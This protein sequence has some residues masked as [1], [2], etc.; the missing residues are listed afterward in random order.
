MKPEVEINNDFMDQIEINLGVRQGDSL[1]ATL[2]CL[3]IDTVIIKLDLRGNISTRSKQ[4]CAYAVDILI[5]ANAKQALSKMFTKLK[6]EVENR[7]AYK[8]K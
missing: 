6:D 5:I 4:I 8:Y 7:F 3:V 1:L 2:F